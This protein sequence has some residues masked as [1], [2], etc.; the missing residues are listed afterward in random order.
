MR[1]SLVGSRGPFRFPLTR[2]RAI[3][4]ASRRVATNASEL[5]LRHGKQRQVT[6]EVTKAFV[7]T[8]HLSLLFL[9]GMRPS[10]LVRCSDV[11]LFQIE[12][13]V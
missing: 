10:K 9:V 7:T 8:K 4:A 5:K 2:A 12:I 1:A 6:M 3:L 11:L 13:V